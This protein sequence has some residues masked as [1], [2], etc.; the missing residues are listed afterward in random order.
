MFLLRAKGPGVQL[1]GGGGLA[2]LPTNHRRERPM[3]RDISP[4]PT[5]TRESGR[6]LRRPSPSQT[7]HGLVRRVRASPP[8]CTFGPLDLGSWVARTGN[9]RQGVK[10]TPLGQ[11]G[12]DA[13]DWCFNRGRRAHVT[14]GVWK[15]AGPGLGSTRLR[16]SVHVM[17]PACFH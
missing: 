6:S 16:L 9:T 8:T 15:L 17:L 4:L 13:A 12:E 5:N 11:R 7:H 1:G 2:P 14:P 3:G 10:L